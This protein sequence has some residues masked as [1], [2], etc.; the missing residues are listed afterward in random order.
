MKEA[1]RY[2]FAPLDTTGWLYG[3]SGEQ[4]ITLAAGVVASGIALDAHAS[5]LLV[6]APVTFAV[7]AAF[8]RWR[9]ASVYEVISIEL[10]IMWRRVSKT[11]E[12]HSI[13]GDNLPPFLSHLD[14]TFNAHHTIAKGVG[15]I[16]DERQHTLT[17]AVEVSSK[18][19]VLCED[20]EQ[21][22][23]LDGWGDAFSTFA[24][25]RAFIVRLSWSETTT[26]RVNAATKPSS[27]SLPT[28][29][30]LQSYFDLVHDEI[31]SAEIHKTIVTLT[32]DLRNVHGERRNKQAT[33]D[34][35]VTRLLEE[36]RL[37]SV[38]LAEAGLGVS[39]PLSALDLR[40]TITTRLAPDHHEQPKA[41][42]LGGLTTPNTVQ[43]IHSGAITRSHLR[44][45]G[46][47]HRTYWIRQWPRMDVGANWLEPLLLHPGVMRSITVH[48]EP[49]APSVS[50]RSIDRNATKLETDATQRSRSGFRIGN[51]HER[52]AQAVSERESELGQGFAEF[53]YIGFVAVSASNS[54][55]LR[56]AC[57]DF[58]QVAAAC[59]VELFALDGHHDAGMTFALPLGQA[60]RR[61]RFS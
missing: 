12:W 34:A 33:T 45:D 16:S 54:D 10:R 56:N 55:H 3:L 49:I 17:I 8:A 36:T 27:E 30:A 23:L 21:E 41:T 37:F 31:R 2:R 39:E 44:I 61:K 24:I 18:Q 40:E 11:D 52:A 48:L 57:L 6:L 22:S 19:F 50:R 13:R 1:R 9:G 25:E 28:N 15:I 53:N 20:N 46:T 47:F 59:G 51:N 32:V 7:A 14:S 35:G 43:R 4:C 38:R 58:E 26:T 42:T 60:P 29:A 5:P